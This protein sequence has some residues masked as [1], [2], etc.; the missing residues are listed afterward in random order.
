MGM[1]IFSYCFSSEPINYCGMPNQYRFG[2]YH[3]SIDSRTPYCV[4]KNQ[5]CECAILGYAV[6]VVTAKCDSI[7]EDI[8]MNCNSIDEVIE[9]REEMYEGKPIGI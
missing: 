8:L 5:H 1:T 3:L 6:N 4:S 2:K 9:Y 7:P